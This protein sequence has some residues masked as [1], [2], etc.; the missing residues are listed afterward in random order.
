MTKWLL[1]AQILVGLSLPAVVA[2]ETMDGKPEPC[3]VERQQR[4]AVSL[5]PPNGV[6]LSTVVIEF[7]YDRTQVAIPG[8]RNDA[9]VKDRF[10]GFP[11]GAISAVN[12]MEGKSRIVVAASAALPVRDSL[13]V[14]TVD[15]CAGASPSADEY[16]CTVSSCVAMNAPVDGCRCVV[17]ID[18][19]EPA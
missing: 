5:V 18:G 10:E 12:D 17:R 16:S 13:F 11:A 7:A 8:K 14:L 19:S 3:R 6:E 15:V 1:A 9:S 4:L 2:G